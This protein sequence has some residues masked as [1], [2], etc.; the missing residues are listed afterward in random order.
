MGATW[1]FVAF[2]VLMLARVPV[3]IALF[4]SSAGYAAWSGLVPMRTVVSM[5]LSGTGGFLLVAIPTFIL[6]AEIMNR[7]TITDRIV[8]FAL[9]LVGHLR[10]SLAQ[11][12]IVSS[13]IFAGMSGSAIADISGLGRIQVRAMREAGFAVPFAAAITAVASTLAP[14]LPP[15]I[16]MVV[17]A[18]AAEVSVGRMF[19]SGVTP[20]FV[21]ALAFMLTVY[22]ISLKH[23]EW[24]RFPLVSWRGR[25]ENFLKAL[26][27]LLTPVILLGGFLSGYWTPTEAGAVASL[28]ALIVA[29]FVYRDIAWR[30]LTDIL[31]QTAISTGNVLLIFA[32]SHIV[33]QLVALEDLPNTLTGQIA[34]LTRD[35]LV[36][37][38]L[39]NITMFVGGMLLE[40]TPLLLI[41]TPFL[42][43]LCHSYGFDPV[44]IGLVC[45]LNLMLGTITPP[46]AIALFAIADAV[47]VPFHVLVRA[48]L[49][50]YIPFFFLILLVTYFPSIAMWLP[51]LA[52]G[53]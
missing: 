30:D 18:S 25:A 33:S 47:R 35:P 42:L 10:G 39:I 44:H 17:Y 36:V 53:Q 5:G 23:P 50:F 11:V 32:S 48:S 13:L 45:V 12:C 52:F 8:Q 9:S 2:I 6:M 19:L 4:V 34:A 31:S 43:Q 22:V 21:M 1:I 38:A 27:A 28:W 41:A 16:I 14:I 49:P 26:P 20:A 29:R 51:R 40:P 3:A 15:S 24:K 46:F 37:L 7:S